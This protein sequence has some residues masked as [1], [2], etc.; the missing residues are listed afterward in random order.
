MI[1]VKLNYDEYSLEVP[2]Q[3]F[4]AWEIVYTIAISKL[5]GT[6]QNFAPGNKLHCRAGSRCWLH[7]VNEI[8]RRGRWSAS[9]PHDLGEQ[10]RTRGVKAVGW[11]RQAHAATGY[12]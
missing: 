8:V 10:E 3:D 6:V 5:P 1:L 4:S 7:A 12:C 11:P 9:A 2:G